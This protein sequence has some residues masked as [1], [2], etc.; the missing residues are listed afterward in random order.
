MSSMLI[1]LSDNNSNA[2]ATSTIINQINGV[3]EESQNVEEQKSLLNNFPPPPKTTFSSKITTT[4]TSTSGINNKDEY[5]DVLIRV[6]EQPDVKKFQANSK[7]LISKC[8]YFHTALSSNWARKENDIFI[9]E[10]PNIKPKVFEVVLRYICSGTIDWNALEGEDFL[11]IWLAAD[12]FML[13]E[14]EKQVRELF[15]K[16]SEKLKSNFISMVKLVYQNDVLERFRSN[17]VDIINTTTWFQECHNFKSLDESIFQSL[18][19]EEENCVHDGVIW[20]LLIL[21]ACSSKM[22]ILNKNK[23]MEWTDK[24][25]ALLKSRIDQFIPHIRFSL[26]SRN[27]YYNNVLPYRH[28]LPADTTTNAAL[29]YYFYYLDED[30]NPKPDVLRPHVILDDS[31]IINHTHIAMIGRWIDTGREKEN[32]TQDS[33]SNSFISVDDNSSL[34]EEQEIPPYNVTVPASTEATKNSNSRNEEKGSMKISWKQTS[35]K[36]LWTLRKNRRPVYPNDSSSTTTPSTTKKENNNER[37]HVFSNSDTKNIPSKTPLIKN[38]PTSSI[39]FSSSQA[40]TYNFKL[41]YRGSRDGFDIGSYNEKCSEQGATVVVVTISHS[42]IILGGYYPVN[43]KSEYPYEVTV[44]S[45]D[46]FIFSFGEGDNPEDDAILSRVSKQYSQHAIC[47]TVQGPGFGNYDLAI[48]LENGN[49]PKKIVCKQKYYE[50]KIITPN[51][52]NEFTFDDIEVFKIIK[53]EV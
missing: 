13:D 41:I 38:S 37:L 32:C 20:N 7:T 2:T 19:S 40:Y 4:T 15:E 28:I 35:L 18:L 25:F 8:N 16:K 36:K 34:N 30:G 31:K 45:P 22:P 53:E 46:A 17:C 39:C 24:E 5:Y 47:R 51:E 14:L 1:M 21:W 6:G 33:C 26:I 12:E 27:D 43:T 9:I 3:N 48:R 11:G 52:S 50:K 44:C 42:R 10:K 29:Q 49:L 23:V